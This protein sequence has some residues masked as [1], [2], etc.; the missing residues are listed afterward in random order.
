MRKF[1]K[2][3]GIF[4]AFTGR[5]GEIKR[6][7]EISLSEGDSWQVCLILWIETLFADLGSEFYKLKIIYYSLSNLRLL[8]Q[9]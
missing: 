6:N 3:M 7:A 8:S 9:F 1:V 5:P 2:K 4:Y